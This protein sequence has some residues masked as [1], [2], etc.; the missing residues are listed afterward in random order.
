MRFSDIQ[1]PAGFVAE[2]GGVLYQILSNVLLIQI[3]KYN[4]RHIFT[5]FLIM[6]YVTL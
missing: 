2:T 4:F 6:Q 1:N 3:L 5:T